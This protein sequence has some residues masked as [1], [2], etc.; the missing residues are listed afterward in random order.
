[1]SI[2]NIDTLTNLICFLDSGF[3]AQNQGRDRLASHAQKKAPELPGT[4]FVFS[5]L[6]EGF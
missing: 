3:S 6:A 4:L 5:L 2:E 1:V